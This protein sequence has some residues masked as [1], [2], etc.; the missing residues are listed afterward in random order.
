[1]FSWLYQL[2]LSFV[3]RVL[4]WFGVSF[5][6]NDVSD[7]VE[8]VQTL[9]ERKGSDEPQEVQ[10]GVEAYSSPSHPPALLP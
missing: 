8:V 10:Q 7:V 1:M 5:G 4:S 9:Q 2:L 6:A 3:A